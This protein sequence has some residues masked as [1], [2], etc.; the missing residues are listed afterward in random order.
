MLS[1]GWPSEASHASDRAFRFRFFRFSK[2]FRGFSRSSGSRGG[3]PKSGEFEGCRFFECF[4][5]KRSGFCACLL[6]FALFS[7]VGYVLEFRK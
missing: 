2:R 6:F 4:A 7:S 3:M 5:G 1:C